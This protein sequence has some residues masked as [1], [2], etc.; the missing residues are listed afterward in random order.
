MPSARRR[1]V[2]DIPVGLANKSIRPSDELAVRDATDES[3]VESIG[4]ERVPDTATDGVS[5][6]STRGTT[7]SATKQGANKRVNGDLDMFTVL[8]VN[9]LG[10]LLAVADRLQRI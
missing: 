8:A 6:L 10:S 2:G 9:E 5:D 3:D 4:T 7:T 1:V